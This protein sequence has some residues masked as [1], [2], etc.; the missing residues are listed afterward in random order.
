M[1][2]FKNEMVDRICATLIRYDLPLQ[3]VKAKI[4]LAVKDY[5]I[6]K[7]ETSLTVYTEG[8]NEIYFKRFLVSKMVA[9]CSE[10]TVRFYKAE[11]DRVFSAINKDFDQISASDVQAY[12]AFKMSGGTSKCS[13]DNSRRVLSS[14]FN[15]LQREEILSKNPMNQVDKIKFHKQKESVFTDYEIELLRE[16]LRDSRERC[17]FEML[18]STGCR[19]S[20]LVSI[21]I[22]DL[23]DDKIYILGKGG[24]YR[25]IYLTAKARIAIQKYLSDRKDRNPYLFPKSSVKLN[26]NT[27]IRSVR[28]LWFLNP[29]FVS[30]NEA[31]DKGNIEQ[32]MRKL[33]KRAGVENV[34]PHR[35]R[36][37]CATAALLKG[38]PI[39]L[40][41]Q[42][43]GHANISTTQI[44][45]DISEKELELAHKKY[46]GG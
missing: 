19:V 27:E 5:D 34:H 43:L 15:W 14:F 29:D 40:V 39:E 4:M 12:F 25:Y 13:C 20:E 16:H 37:T 46:V 33:G 7:T 10:K 35:F 1:P 18:L 8:K 38:M 21:K 24:K 28:H 17:A 9:G 42:M 23:E 26:D 6:A 2:D 32:M 3:E 41:S 22:E 45:L 36:R 11:L 44:Y 31:V 30:E